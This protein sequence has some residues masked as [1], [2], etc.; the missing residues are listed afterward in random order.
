MKYKNQTFQFRPNP[1]TEFK[2][3]EIKNRKRGHVFKEYIIFPV[4]DDAK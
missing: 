1:L 3:I 4:D 2:L